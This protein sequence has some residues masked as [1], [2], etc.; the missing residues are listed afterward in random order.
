VGFFVVPVDVKSNTGRIWVFREAVRQ[1]S[2]G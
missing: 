1:V 2:V